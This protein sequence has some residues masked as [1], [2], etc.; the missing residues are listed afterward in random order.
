VFRSIVFLSVTVLLGAVP[1]LPQDSSSTKPAAFVVPPDIAAK[2]NPV[3]PTAAEMGTVRKLYGYD[4]VMCHGKEGGGDGD[5]AASLQ[6]KMKDYRDPTAL[7][8]MS[9]GELFYI[10]QKGKGEMPSEG[11]RAKD[12]QIWTMVVLVHSFAKK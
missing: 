12:D 5:M 3:H 1:F 8:G 6:T 10:I 7:K 2:I 11:D 9:D 4:C